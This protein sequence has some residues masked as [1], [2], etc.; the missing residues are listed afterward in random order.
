MPGVTVRGDSFIYFLTSLQLMISY[1]SQNYKR[2]KNYR[3]KRVISLMQVTLYVLIER[4]ITKEIKKRNMRVLCLIVLWSV[5]DT[6][7]GESG[8]SDSCMVVV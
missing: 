6:V 7:K 1:I 2:W 3:Y 8:C 4:T 5:E